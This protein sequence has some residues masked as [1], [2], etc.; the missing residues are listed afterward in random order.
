MAFELI[1][2]ADLV[3]NTGRYDTSS[4]YTSN[5]VIISFEGEFKPWWRY[6]GRVSRLEFINSQLTYTHSQSI[7]LHSPNLITWEATDGVGYRMRIF[8]RAGM[9]PGNL[10]IW[11]FVD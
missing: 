2:S 3:E 1:E 11:E 7:Y 9:Q 4:I 6:L 10:K 5:S 8:F